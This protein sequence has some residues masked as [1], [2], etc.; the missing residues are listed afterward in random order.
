M[1]D[2]L[3][4]H[5]PKRGG[6]AFSNF[7]QALNNTQQEFIADALT[8][9]QDTSVTTV[10]KISRE[11]VGRASAKVKEDVAANVVI[12][13]LTLNVNCCCNEPNRPNVNKMV[14]RG[15]PFES[16]SRG[17]YMI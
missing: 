2:E 4:T 9:A 15:R 6:K 11:D 3:L 14:T 13:S 10:A 17:Y 5:L 12:E 16:Q 7:I 1:V 8:N